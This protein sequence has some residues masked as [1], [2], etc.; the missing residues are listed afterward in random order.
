MR[1][2]KYT[3]NGSRQSADRPQSS[4]PQF[5]SG[6]LDNP[7]CG[8]N[9]L[10]DFCS[11]FFGHIFFDGLRRALHQIFGFFQAKTGNRAHFLDNRNLFR[12]IHAFQGNRELRLL[13][14]SSSGSANSSSS[15]ESKSA[16]NSLPA[17]SP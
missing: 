9:R 2:G 11:V 17:S 13:F 1:N 3:F 14:R 4:G 12:G 7:T 6:N 16:K 5:R 10:L 8:F 15:L